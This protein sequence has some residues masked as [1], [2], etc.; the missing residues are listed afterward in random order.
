MEP[1][2]PAEDPRDIYIYIYIYER[3]WKWQRRVVSATDFV[4][5][6]ELVISGEK[7]LWLIRVDHRACHDSLHRREWFWSRP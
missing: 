3:W 6:F 2:V 5:T 1:S 7:E 4:A